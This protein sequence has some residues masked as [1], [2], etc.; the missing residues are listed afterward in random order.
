MDTHTFLTNADTECTIVARRG[1]RCIS[2][3]DGAILIET[4]TESITIHLRKTSHEGVPFT[5]GDER[6]NQTPAELNSAG[7]SL[8]DV[9]Q[10][11]GDGTRGTQEHTGSHQER[12]REDV[13]DTTNEIDQFCEQLAPKIL[14]NWEERSSRWKKGA[15]E[16]LAGP[17]TFFD[18]INSPIQ[19]SFQTLNRSETKVDRFL[20]P[21]HKMN[22]F[23]WWRSFSIKST[24]A[25]CD[26]KNA[27][28]ETVKSDYMTL[29]PEKKKTIQKQVQRYV[30]QGEVLWL[31]YE[32]TKG[33]LITVPQFITTNQ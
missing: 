25:V 1:I 32:H 3:P 33:L 17:K 9:A 28:Y 18:E 29:L 20:L 22:L 10:E 15:A 4:E 7:G 2:H 24:N 31:M 12:D 11:D 8:E 30:A 21:F 19:W 14:Q 13:V 26:I 5:I 16:L 6:N 23:V 27:L